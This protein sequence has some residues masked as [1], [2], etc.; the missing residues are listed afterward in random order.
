MMEVFYC[1][2]CGGALI[3]VSPQQKYHPECARIVQKERD[4]IRHMNNRLNPKPTPTKRNPT[5]SELS[6]KAREKG[7]TYGQYV[8]YM[9]GT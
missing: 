8:A 2:H 5:L 4:R 7:M 1:E 6:K 9:K 3:K